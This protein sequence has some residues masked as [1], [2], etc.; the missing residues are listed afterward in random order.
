ML[1]TWMCSFLQSRSI[2]DKS[3][4]QQFFLFLWVTKNSRSESKF[5]KSRCYLDM[6]FAMVALLDQ[7]VP[8]QQFFWVL[9]VTQRSTSVSKIAKS[10]CYLD[11]LFPIVAPPNRLW[12]VMARAL[13]F[14][15]WVV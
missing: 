1:A 5:D 6:L 10:K 3:P 2:L 9:W 7:Q 14:A 4:L 12:G 11:M 13:P 8:L 15:T